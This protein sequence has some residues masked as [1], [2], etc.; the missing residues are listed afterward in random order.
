[1]TQTIINITP[2]QDALLWGT[3]LGDGTIS[4]RSPISWENR[5]MTVNTPTTYRVKIEHSLEQS[6][7]V[8]WK[9][10]ILKPLCGD[11]QGPVKVKHSS[12]ERT[13]Y[14]LMFYTK[15]SPIYHEMHKM[16]YEPNLAKTKPSRAISNYTKV[17]RPELIE[18][19]PMDP[20]VLASWY[21]DDG[22]A[23]GD[24]DAGKLATQG[25]TLE[26]NKL[27]LTYLQKW[28]LDATITLHSAKKSQYYISFPAKGKVFRKFVDIIS[29]RVNEVPGLAYKLNRLR[30]TP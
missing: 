4:V 16:L 8:M 12:K 27:L 18:R 3:M 9:Y 20:L 22:N 11:C 17:I 6:D 25:F 21:M 30:M 24:C 14:A 2:D 1:M 13:T 23:R 19:L 26:D 28:G 10:N 15:A 29:G 7:Y 5:V